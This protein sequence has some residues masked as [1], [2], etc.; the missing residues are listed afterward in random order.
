MSETHVHE[1]HWE[2][3]RPEGDSWFCCGQCREV[4]HIGQIERRLN[5]TERLSAL[6]AQIIAKLISYTG[7]AKVLEDYASALEGDDE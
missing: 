5:A 4:I 7:G 2:Y 3:N 1:W 6:D